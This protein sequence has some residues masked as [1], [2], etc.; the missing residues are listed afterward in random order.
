MRDR[1][2]GRTVCI[3]PQTQVQV[4]GGRCQ[5]VCHN[6]LADGAGMH[7]KCSSQE[8]ELAEHAL[9]KIGVE[10]R[11]DHQHRGPPPESRNHGKPWAEGNMKKPFGQHS[12]YGFYRTTHARA[13]P[14]TDRCLHL[15][16]RCSVAHPSHMAQCLAARPVRYRQSRV[17]SMYYRAMA[18]RTVRSRSAGSHGL[19]M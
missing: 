16:A 18:S 4:A 13:A 10:G 9:A 7:Q 1:V 15:P 6:Y 5:A 11:M 8:G 17:R 14:M 19:I 2:G 3:Q 12:C